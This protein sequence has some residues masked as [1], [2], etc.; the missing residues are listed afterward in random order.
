MDPVNVPAIFEVRKNV[1]SFGFYRQIRNLTTG[2][3]TVQEGMRHSM[4]Y[5]SCQA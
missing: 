2:I 3:D 5:K 4:N 1:T